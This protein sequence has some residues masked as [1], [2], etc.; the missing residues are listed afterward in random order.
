MLSG[1][2]ET[3]KAGFIHSRYCISA[4]LRIGARHY[5]S[6]AYAPLNSP[7]LFSFDFVV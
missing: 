7:V 5:L 2:Y 3:E 1:V 4:L 6:N